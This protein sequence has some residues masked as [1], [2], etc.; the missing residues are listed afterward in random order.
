MEEHNDPLKDFDWVFRPEDGSTPPPPPHNYRDERAWQFPVYERP[1]TVFAESAVPDLHQEVSFART[2]GRHR[3]TRRIGTVA[4][5]GLA[6]IATGV[7][8]A[9]L[10]PRPVQGAE[11]APQP[12]TSA[13]VRATPSWSAGAHSK[14]PQPRST[15]ET[16]APPYGVAG[17]T[18]SPSPWGIILRTPK[19]TLDPSRTATTQL[20][21]KPSHS[22]ATHGP[23]PSETP[24]AQPS[25]SAPSPLPSSKPT[26]Q[27][28]KLPSGPPSS[29]KP[30]TA[31]SA[32][33]RM[34][35]PKDKQS[36]ESPT[37]SAPI[38]TG[39]SASNPSAAPDT[40]GR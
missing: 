34:D 28:S 5:L 4:G 2:I 9:L 26:I 3:R 23:S 40:T 13:S 8:A 19:H 16:S 25:E 18:M 15:T 21:P 7:G 39:R 35:A 14:A 33:N 11:T 36:A 12:S 22:T 30:S 6:A 31:P 38:T 37:T 29:Q 24:T 32:S 17:Y 10:T 1:A 20:T 27:P